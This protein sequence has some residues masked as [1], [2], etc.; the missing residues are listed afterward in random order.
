LTF[1]VV[2][3]SWSPGLPLRQEDQGTLWTVSS[4]QV[5]APLLDRSEKDQRR[6]ATPKSILTVPLSDEH[7][8]VLDM[9]FFKGLT[10]G[11][12]AAETGLSSGAVKTNLCLALQ[13]LHLSLTPQV[14][15]RQHI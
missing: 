2:T 6:S 9:T 12:I 1:G 8:G 5:P 15:S 4:L 11:E 13:G 10:I 14:A 7:F 3:P